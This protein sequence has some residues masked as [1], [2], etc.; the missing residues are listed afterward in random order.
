MGHSPIGASSCERFWECPGS[1]ILAKNAPPQKAS[2]AAAQGTVAHSIAER[3]L[4]K[5]KR[6]DTRPLGDILEA[7][8]FGVEVDADML[9]AVSVYVDH[10][11]DTMEN[12]GVPA[13]RLRV[14]VGFTLSHLDPDAYGTCDTVLG[15]AKRPVIFDYKHGAGV[16]V[17]VGGNKQTLYYALGYFYSLSRR[18]RANVKGVET[19]IVQPR[20]PH[21]DGAV[22]SMRYT[23]T[24]LLEFE[25]GLRKAIQ[26]VRR[27]DDT[28]KAGSHCK[29]CPAK[30][31]CSEARAFAL[32]A[33]FTDFSDLEDDEFEG[34]G[35]NNPIDYTR[36]TPEQI[37][38][39]LDKIPFIL[40]WCEKV[41]QHALGLAEA[42]KDI[43][44]HILTNR[45]AR[46]RWTKG[47]ENILYLLFGEKIYGKPKLLS[48]NQ[49]EKFIPRGERH[50]LDTLW[51]KPETGRTLARVES[52]RKK[53]L[54]SLM[55]DFIDLDI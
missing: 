28:L 31:I 36:L 19:V 45:L 54:P 39:V 48:P 11:L 22:R 51:E 4:K 29:F 9:D 40:D 17:E 13:G 34:E 16:P 24:E 15:L 10:V 12:S 1:V 25:D 43:P 55:T 53:L 44:G 52:K 20:C 35:L 46:R 41:S 8:G 49:I 30:P 42:G 14:E 47:A 7:D 18:E 2:F 27:G 23:V 32:K 38:R 37:G 6:V 26:R 3:Y 21:P 50:V 5:G 33:V